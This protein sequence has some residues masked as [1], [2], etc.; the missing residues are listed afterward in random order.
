QALRRY[1]GAARG[2][3]AAA[4]IPLRDCAAWSGH[5]GPQRAQENPQ[6]HD[7]TSG[8]FRTSADDFWNTAPTMV[9]HNGGRM[10]FHLCGCELLAPHRRIGRGR[11]L[12][13]AGATAQTIPDSGFC[14]VLLCI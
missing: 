3:A 9:T 14:L 10:P 11:G 4:R 6:V 1:S 12:D 2:E 7:Q 13:W 5:P 8:K